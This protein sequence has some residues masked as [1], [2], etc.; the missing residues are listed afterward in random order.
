MHRVQHNL[1]SLLQ[2]RFPAVANRSVLEHQAHAMMPHVCAHVDCEQGKCHT[3]DYWHEY[4]VEGGD[5]Q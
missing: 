1:H 2:A 4:E 5:L 3:H